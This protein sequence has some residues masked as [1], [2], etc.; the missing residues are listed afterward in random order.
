MAAALFQKAPQVFEGDQNPRTADTDGGSNKWEAVSV[1]EKSD[2][3]K[4]RGKK[5]ET[6]KT[7]SPHQQRAKGQAKTGVKR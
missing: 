3:I 5:G 6:L 2:G 7:N 1:E 4:R